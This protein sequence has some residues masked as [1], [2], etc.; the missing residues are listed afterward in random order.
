M[1]IDG[2]EAARRLIPVGP[3]G[4]RPL[5]EGAQR[6]GEFQEILEKQLGDQGLRLSAHAQKRIEQSPVRFGTAEVDRVARA[7]D[8]AASKGSRESLVLLDDMALVV[9]VK[10]RTIITAVDMQRMKDNIFTN[11]DSAVIV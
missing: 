5:A 9:S 3:P 6:P 1:A 4:Q 11:I 8:L 10:N 2:L 7:V